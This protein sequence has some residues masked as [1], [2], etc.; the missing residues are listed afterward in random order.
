M[1]TC[2]P[3]NEDA[4]PA[5][6]ISLEKYTTYGYCDVLE[7]GKSAPRYTRTVKVDLKK[8][9]QTKPTVSWDSS[10]YVTYVSGVEKLKK[11]DSIVAILDG[12]NATLKDWK[13]AGSLAKFAGEEDSGFLFNMMWKGES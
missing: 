3:T 5:D 2:T 12:A 1:S 7:S 10:G 8:G 11:G 6:F 4:T 9:A 13:A